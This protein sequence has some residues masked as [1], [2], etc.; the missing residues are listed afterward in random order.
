MGFE[1]EQDPS[2]KFRGFMNQEDEELWRNFVGFRFCRWRW[3][4]L[5]KKAVT[6]VK[7]KKSNEA[8]EEEDEDEAFFQWAWENEAKCIV[9]VVEEFCEK[10]MAGIC[11]CKT[12][13]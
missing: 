4:T 13:V 3:R 12:V 2:I 6:F 7:M 5:K 8:D 9:Y 1:D 10:E 11:Y